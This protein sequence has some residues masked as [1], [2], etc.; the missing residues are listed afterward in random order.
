MEKSNYTKLFC[1]AHREYEGLPD[2]EIVTP[3]LVGMNEANIDLKIRDYYPNLSVNNLNWNELEAI[4]Y[5]WKNVHAP[6]KGQFQYSCRLPL[7][8]IEILGL[9]SRYKFIVHMQYIENLKKQF[10]KYHGDWFLP[11]IKESVKEISPEITDEVFEKAENSP[12]ILSRNCFIAAEDDYNE[13]CEW[14]FKVIFLFNDKMGFKTVDDIKIFLKTKGI[15]D[16]LLTY[17]S[18]VSGFISER[19]F[20]LYIIWKFGDLSKVVSPKY[21]YFQKMPLE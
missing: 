15:P 18:R 13:F 14:L 2:N 6:A 12:V 8:E 16:E 20:T 5:I 11:V 4:Y 9:L 19:L 7:S 21:D 17:Q 3:V 10:I 1:I